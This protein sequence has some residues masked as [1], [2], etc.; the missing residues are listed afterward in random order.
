MTTNNEQAVNIERMKDINAFVAD[1]VR[2]PWRAHGAPIYLYHN[3]S[4]RLAVQP[5]HNSGFEGLW[6]HETLADAGLYDVELDGETLGRTFVEQVCHHLSINDMRYIR[7]HVTKAIE[8]WEEE[9]A[10]SPR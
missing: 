5:E 7:D 9:H 6:R 3:E 10:P 2:T 4:S 1:H 8:A